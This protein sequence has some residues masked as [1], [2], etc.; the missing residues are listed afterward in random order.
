MS[1]GS[2]D[3]PKADDSPA[4]SSRE[5]ALYNSLEAARARCHADPT[6]ELWHIRLEIAAAILAGELPVRPSAGRRQDRTTQTLRAALAQFS[7]VLVKGLAAPQH[8]ERLHKLVVDAFDIYDA[9]Q[10]AL[11]AD[12]P[13]ASTPHY[14]LS[15]FTRNGSQV[16]R[17]YGAIR[18][19]E[20]PLAAFELC[21]FYAEHPVLELLTDYLG[22]RPVLSQTKS[23]IRKSDPSRL[24]PRAVFHQDGTFLHVPTINVWLALTSAG[25]DSP[26]IELLPKPITQFEP[27]G[28]ERAILPYEIDDDALY[29]KYGRNAF[30]CPLF[31]RGT[32]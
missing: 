5:S 1:T 28:G 18:L 13:V 4:T 17:T 26:G 11:D 7:C 23:V 15:D 12:K 29:A 22:K 19:D 16:A 30:W 8:I 31:A 20:S 6:L 25:F 24:P 9:V 2:I 3:S 14:V 32:R 27:I 10:L 21:E